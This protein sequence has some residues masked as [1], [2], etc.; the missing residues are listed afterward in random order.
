MKLQFDLSCCVFALPP[1]EPVLIPPPDEPLAAGAFDVED[2][3]FE[4]PD[5][6]EPEVEVEEPVVDRVV[7]PRVVETLSVP[8]VPARILTLVEE[9]PPTT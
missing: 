5:V 8:R 9:P 3:E 4:E 1:D 2:P 6:E 7:L